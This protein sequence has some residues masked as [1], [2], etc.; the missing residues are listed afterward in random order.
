MS[1]RGNTSR[2]RVIVVGGG[3]VGC[4]TALQLVKHGFD[5]TLIERDG[6]GAHASGRNAGNLNP[7]VGAPPALVPF[8][9]EAFRLHRQLGA[10]LTQLGYAEAAATPTPRLHLGLGDDD[11][12]P[13]AQIHKVLNATDGFESGRLDREAL[14]RLEPGLGPFVA[15]G[16]LTKGNLTLDGEA[17][18]RCVADAASRLGMRQVRGAATA[19]TTAGDCVTGVSVGGDTIACE[20]VVFATGPWVAQIN[21]WLGVELNVRPLKGEILMLRPAG[22]SPDHD[23]TWG[24]TSLYTRRSGEIWVGVTFDDCGLDARPTDRAKTELLAAA[25]RIWPQIAHGA[26]FDHR[27]ALRP[28]TPDGLPI[29][30]RAK[31]WQNA[32]I[33]NG[34]GSKGMLLSVGIAKT[35]GDLLL[36]VRPEATGGV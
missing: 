10:E 2:R 36:D 32:W 28:M 30:G 20:D 8:A 4:A 18:T 21:R 19:V 17:F 12:A 31:G 13:L 9:L 29:A 16:L 6:V 23:L 35:I 3:A 25:T 5:V 7:L 14:L 27:A 1:M 33:A 11:E 15:F 24:T 34:G 22:A 26:V